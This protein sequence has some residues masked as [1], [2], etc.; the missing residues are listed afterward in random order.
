MHR[1]PLPALASSGALLGA[2][3]AGGLFLA[4]PAARGD[5]LTFLDRSPGH[6]LERLKSTRPAVR[7]SAAFALGRLGHEAYY[8]VP[9]LARHLQDKDPGVRDAAASALGEIVFGLRDQEVP[10]NVALQW[11]QAGARLVKAL[12]VDTEPD[13]RVRRSAA[14][15]LGT[16]GPAAA[17]ALP[18]LKKALRDTNPAVRQNAAWAV[19]RVGTADGATVAELCDLLRDANPLVR[20]DAAGALGE[21]GREQ[22]AAAARPLFEALKKEADEVVLRTAL[23]ALSRRGQPEHAARAA[24]LYPLLGHKDPD[25]RRAAAFVLGSMKGEPAARALPVLRQALKD[26]DPGIQALAAAGLANVGGDAAPAV[27]DLADALARSPDPIVRRNAALALANIGEA[28]RP[29]VPELAAALKPRPDAPRDP[30]KRRP[31][32]EARRYAAEALAR[33]EFPA[34]ERAIPALREVIRGDVNQDVRHRSIGALFTVPAADLEKAGLDKV[35]AR[36]LEEAPVRSPEWGRSNVLV[37]YDAARVLARRLEGRAPDKT[38]D[39]LVE[40]IRDKSLL[41][42]RGTDATIKGT[43]T[44]R[45][46]GESGTREVANDD[47]RYMAADALAFLGAKARANPEVAKALREAAEDKSTKLAESAK[48]AMKIL[49]IGP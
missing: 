16:F 12:S 10:F 31:Y 38:S 24:D 4:G 46:S 39:L 15:A 11:D 33:I 25:T 28:S 43:G 27:P 19:G 22:A 14:Y 44:E 32:D 47:A 13:P 34:N 18:A 41:I 21:L 17:E 2:L 8:A 9:E 29:A 36:V 42:Y 30:L 1:T 40:M 48:R 20:R 49:E 5:S 7:R 26:A 6:W 23:D 3:V 37:R 35:L 45:G